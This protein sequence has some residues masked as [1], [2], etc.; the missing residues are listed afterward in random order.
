MKAM[1]LTGPDEPFQLMEVPDPS[2]G[3]GEAV[4]RVI[5]CGS[6]LTIQH[7]R[8]GRSKVDYPRIIGHEITAEIVEVGKG[9]TGLKV[10]DPVTAYYYLTC[11][12][13]HWCRS[14]RETLCTGM[15][16]TVGRACDGGY[17]DYIKLAENSFIKLPEGLD[18]KSHPAEVGVI[19]DAIATPVKVVR[20]ARI[21]PAEWVAVI[22]GGGGVGLQMIQVAK[23][24]KARV[25]AVD[26]RAEKFDACK[27]AG[28]D[29]VI[30]AS[31]GNV[32]EAL[33][34]LTDGIGV[35]VATDFVASK[36]SLE[37]AFGGLNRGGRLVLLGGSAKPFTLD[38]ELLKLEREVM[39]SKYATRAEVR[40]SL[41][42]VARGEVWPIV[43]EVV[44]L[45]QAE[46][47]H[48]RVEQGLVVGRA[49]VRVN[50]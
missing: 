49:A 2:P 31:K 18:Y 33:L 10:G 42:I 37:T 50:D 43:S 47:L 45:E 38:S 3:P 13:C 30:D 15:P 44:P 24:A 20:K 46:A 16:G 22:G 39:G 14:G 36:S 19:M 32:S 17:A 6:G 40:E 48:E 28:A 1:V 25:V 9:V 27:K 4:A 35:D 34:D 26:T 12:E 29:A 23:W 5:T 8:A 11:G 41:E 21:Q 7:I